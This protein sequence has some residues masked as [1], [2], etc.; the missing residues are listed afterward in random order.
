M[1]KYLAL[2]LL[3]VFV[4]NTFAQNKP[5]F[6]ADVQTIKSYDKL[7]KPPVHPILFVGSSSIRKWDDLQLAFG[8]YNVLNRG[9]GGA[10]ISDIKYYLK[11]I[12]F[13]YEPRQIVLY[14]GEN[15]VVAPTETADTIFNRTVNLYQAIRA[16][17]PDVQIVYI[18]MKPSP[19]RD[20]FRE[21]TMAANNL[22]RKFLATQKNV[23]FVDVFALM[24][25]DGHSRPELFV[26]D[27]LHMNQLGYDI[28]NKAVK[29]YLL[30]FEK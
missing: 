10:V 13:D 15:D 26:S 17:M 14:V 6:Y 4:L 3:L 19:S 8:Q 24:L 1:K 22:I 18:A 30:K 16:K 21:K 20:Q 9:I 27:M 5:P 7:F 2:L 11:D 29:P 25:K 12:V 23:V 28:W